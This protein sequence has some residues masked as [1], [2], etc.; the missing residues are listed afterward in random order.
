MAYVLAAAALMKLVVIADGGGATPLDTLTPFYRERSAPAVPLGLR[1][2]YCVGL[3][4]ALLAMALISM[5]HEHRAPPA[6]TCRLPK[7]AR[8]ANR[9]A[10]CIVIFCLPAAGDRLGSLSLVAVTTG[11]SAWALLFELWGKSC[12]QEP[13]FGA[14]AGDKCEYTARCGR[15]RLQEATKSDGEIDIVELGRSEKTAAVAVS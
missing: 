6:A 14:G 1:L 3:G 11:L 13:L 2:Y 15:R 5:S 12:R 7:A 4:A 9:V 10:V 8:L